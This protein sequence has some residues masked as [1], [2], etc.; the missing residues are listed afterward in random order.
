[1]EEIKLY[2]AED[3]Q[4]FREGICSYLS[5]DIKL[6]QS[7]NDNLL[8][9]SGKQVRPLMA[10]LL[11]RAI[12]GTPCTEDGVRYAVSS[13]LLHNATLLH[14]DV[15]DKS[16][17]RRGKPTLR[18]LMGPEVSVLVGDFWLV[19]ALRAIM[20]SKVGRDGALKVFSNTLTELAEG[21]MLQLQK[22][23][24]CDT[25]FDD[26][27]AIIYRKT[28]SLF[29]ASAVS[30]ALSV[31][32]SPEHENAAR[33]YAEN[34]GYAFQMMDDI[35]DYEGDESVGK[36]LGVDILEQKITLP[37]LCAMDNAPAGES[38]S[39]RQKI[40]DDAVSARDEV[41]DFVRRYEGV[42]RARV[43]LKE[44]VTKAVRA[45]DVLAPGCEKDYLIKLAEYIAVRT[46]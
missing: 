6:L 7:V 29:V 13:E 31:E 40:R 30:A 12:S 33:V 5:S 41:V 28:S 4:R 25:D 23:S 27:L 1:M 26:Y 42:A 9:N 3:W 36:P 11:S 19:C 2:L 16:D 46:R 17:T 14:D 39:L 34:I 43:V 45:L 18:S 10:M 44:Y 24:T 21:E 38:L 35:F 15:A 37:L 22:A 8:A 32:A 20:D